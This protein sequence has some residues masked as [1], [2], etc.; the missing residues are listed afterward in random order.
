[1]TGAPA[2]ATAAEPT[3]LPVVLPDLSGM[4]EAVQQQLREAYASL[5]RMSPPRQQAHQPAAEPRRGERGEAY[6]ELGKLLMAAK[7]LD[8]AERCFR[9]AQVLA[10]AD[11]R[12]AY[13]LG[14]L[15][16]SRGELTKA[17]EYFEEVLRR[18]PADFAALV[19]LGHVYTELDRPEEAERVLTRARSVAPKA[20]AVWYELG[21]AS[22]ARQDYASAVQHLEEAL[23]LNPA[24][25]VIHY[26]L[27]MAYRGLGDLDK[28]QSSLDATSGR[29]GAGATVTV[30]DPLMA[31]V[32]AILRSPEVF[33]ELGQQAS[34]RGEWPEALVQFRKAIALAPDNAVMRLNLAQ[35]LNRAGDARAAL[36]ELEA[37]IRVDPSLAAA[38]FMLG[39]LLERSGRDREAID[40]YTATVSFDPSFR[41]A[42]IRLADALRRVG[43]LDA[44]LSSYRRVLE[45][46]PNSEVAQFGEAMAFARQSRHAEAR[47][48]LRV[49]MSLHPDQPAFPQALARLLAASPD[50]QVRDGQ[51]ALDLVRA[52][53]QEHKTTSVAETMAMALAEVGRFAEAVEWQRLAISVAMDAGHADAAQRMAANLTLY[54]R[55][56]PCRTPWRDDDPE[57]RPGPEV[58]PELLGPP[59]F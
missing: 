13:Y 17:A 18:R 8:V 33:W 32:S 40:Q 3:L 36:A 47:E 49:A 16:I 39:T 34:A 6:G 37:A 30:P 31:E 23:R 19:W 54:Q 42:H 21:R 48:R 1:M 14:H 2:Q 50:P 10:P 46:E 38:H 52:L 9:N 28:A 7:Y 27:A 53:A 45:L 35:T 5:L 11:F 15:S 41:E 58:E 20:P 24:A 22:L 44:A 4:H 29:G 57:Y 55:H 59:P 51:Q 26:P 25:A 12:W 43:R 56:E